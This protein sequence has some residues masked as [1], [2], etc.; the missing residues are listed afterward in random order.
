MNKE[1]RN[2]FDPNAWANLNNSENGN[3]KKNTQVVSSQVNNPQMDNR[4]SETEIRDLVAAIVSNC[5]CFS[6]DYNDWLKIGFA[7]AGELGEGGRTYFHQLSQLSGKYN[8]HDCDVKYNNCLRTYRS[9]GNGVNISTLYWMAEQ[10]G[11]DLKQFAR[12]HH[13][14]QAA[15]EESAESACKKVQKCKVQKI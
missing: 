10:A 14:E 3:E 5:P 2:M 4:S 15:Q 1:N 7:L 13:H 6:D 12:E 9:N 11:V 8:A